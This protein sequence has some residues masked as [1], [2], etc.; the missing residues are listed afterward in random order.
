M[1]TGGFILQHK[2]RLLPA[3]V[4]EFSSTETCFKSSFLKV[5]LSL[6]GGFSVVSVSLPAAKLSL[7]QEQG[8]G[9]QMGRLGW[10]ASDQQGA[11][12]CKVSVPQ[13]S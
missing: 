1:V 7:A 3:P 4:V 12:S 2:K 10:G 13:R 5:L 6:T 8:R 11:A 9:R